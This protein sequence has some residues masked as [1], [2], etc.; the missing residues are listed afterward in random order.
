MAAQ[1]AGAGFTLRSDSC[2]SSTGKT[3]KG[4]T[5]LS[6]PSMTTFAMRPVG[7]GPFKL[8]SFD[9]SRIQLERNPKF[10]QEPVDLEAE[11]YDPKTQ[12]SFGLERIAGRS[13]P[14]LDV[15]V[16]NSAPELL[17]AVEEARCLLVERDPDERRRAR[18]AAAAGSRGSSDGA[19]PRPWW[20]PF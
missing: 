7:S 6:S 8:V 3:S 11:G 18:E 20:W 12:G 16:L 17:A 5:E 10:R 1:T 4:F 14:F 2:H 19:A 13:P 15:L 9:T